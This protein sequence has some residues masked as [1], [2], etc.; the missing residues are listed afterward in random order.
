MCIRDREVRVQLVR[1]GRLAL[2]RDVLDVDLL[3][4]TLARSIVHYDDLRLNRAQERGCA[5][6]VETSMPVHR[7]Q[8]DAPELVHRARQLQLARPVRVPQRCHLE[9]SVICLLY[10][11]PSP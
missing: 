9:W 4:Q 10:T 5:G 2:P 3:P 1:G 8:I 6:V 11:S 7:V